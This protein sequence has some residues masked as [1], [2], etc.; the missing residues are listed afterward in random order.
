MALLCNLE[1]S[2][3]QEQK[4][5]GIVEART[6]QESTRT[7]FHYLGELSIQDDPTDE[8]VERRIES[9]LRDDG[10]V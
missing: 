9:S 6:A 8:D 10:K 4:F 7:P 5:S 1:L 2:K 3:F